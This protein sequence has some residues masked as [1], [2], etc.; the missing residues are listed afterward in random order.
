MAE[1]REPRRPVAEPGSFAR[2]LTGL[3]QCLKWLFLSLL[4]SILLEWIGMVLWWEE[5]GLLHSR[6]MLQSELSYLEG[7]LRRSLM[8]KTSADPIN[9]KLNAINPAVDA[10]GNPVPCGGMTVCV[11][12]GRPGLGTVW[13]VEGTRCCELK[14]PGMVSSMHGMKLAPAGT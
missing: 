13:P 14:S 6:L 12:S 8:T 11:A 2:L 7:D 5:Q 10:P 9:S 1:I 3:A 4:F